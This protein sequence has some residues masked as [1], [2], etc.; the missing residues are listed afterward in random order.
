MTRRDG[1][2]CDGCGDEHRWGEAP[3]YIESEGG[4]LCEDCYDEYLEKQ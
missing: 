3:A 4:E 2:I 1:Y